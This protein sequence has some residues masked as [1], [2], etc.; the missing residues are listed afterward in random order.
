[1]RHPTF[2][3][4]YHKVKYIQVPYLDRFFVLSWNGRET[5]RISAVNFAH[6]K[7]FVTL[8]YTLGRKDY[9]KKRFQAFLNKVEKFNKYLDR[10]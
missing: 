4:G 10:N 5:C 8:Y 2:K 3:D 1:M 6:M 7:D 9:T